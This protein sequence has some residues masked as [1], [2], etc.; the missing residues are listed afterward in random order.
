MRKFNAIS[1]R[2]S[3]GVKLCRDVYGVEAQQILDPVFMADPEKV[4]APLIEASDKK[5]TEPF[6]AAYILDPTPEKRKA[7]LHISEKL[8]GI[9]IINLLDGISR[10]FEE[11]KQKMALDN[12]IENLKTEDW[13]YYLSHAEYVV[14]DSCHGASFAIIFQKNFMAIGNQRRGVSRF[15][16]L[17]NLFDCNDRIVYDAEKLIDNEIVM[18]P[19]DYE[20]INAIMA[21][22]RERSYEWLNHALNCPV[23]QKVRV[24]HVPKTPRKKREGLSDGFFRCKIVA[25][26]LKSYG[27]RDVVA[28]AGRDNQNLLKLLEGDSFFRVRRV[29]DENSAGFYAIGLARRSGKKTVV[30][31]GAGLSAALREAKSQGIPL[32]AVTTDS[33]DSNSNLFGSAVKR[34]VTLPWDISVE[35]E[36]RIRSMLIDAV[37]ETDHYGKGPVHINIPVEN[38]GEERP[39]SK[40]LLL[41]RRNVAEKITLFDADAVWKAKAERLK[42]LRRILIVYGQNEKLSARDEEAVKLFAEKYNCVIIKDNLS[43]LTIDKAVEPSNVLDSL[44]DMDF[45]DRLWA[46]AVITV[47]G[48]SS[49]SEKL[50]Q[51][52]LSDGRDIG[53]WDVSQNGAVNHCFHNI[54][55]IFECPTGIFFRRFVRHAGD[56]VNNNSY[57]NAWLTECSRCNIPH[58]GKYSKLYA[59][60]R[61]VIGMPSDTLLGIG[62]GRVMEHINRFAIN[63]TITVT[64]PTKANGGAGSIASFL[65]QAEDNDKECFLLIDE[66]DFMKDMNSLCTYRAGK[67]V[68]I[69]L[70]GDSGR[71]GV[72]EAL[73]KALGFRYMVSRSQEEF[74]AH[75]ADFFDSGEQPVIFEVAV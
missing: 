31:G 70:L 47:G 71:T 13:L 11:N 40:A 37:L 30:C 8:G 10:L 66:E 16:S 46:D 32:I 18:Q 24:L 5:E 48:Q 44:S 73:S 23:E 29:V 33:T 25:E 3:D 74:D 75:I 62:S 53:H 61:A 7:L 69:M 2:E 52:L 50:V 15:Q 39:S 6:M 49:F 67:N 36:W 12:C 26:Y 35:E 20:K 38:V 1:L 22:Q 9:K 60:E 54:L 58:T 17:G 64:A 42:Q 63:P 41:K 65:G 55:R 28:V 19:V 72:I 68:H 59:V 45:C 56:A 51:K 43:N 14:T 27:I 4:Y 21:K 34:S 57:Y